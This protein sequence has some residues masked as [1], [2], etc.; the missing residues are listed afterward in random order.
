[1]VGGGNYGGKS[2]D[3]I[4]VSSD[5]WKLFYINDIDNSISAINRDLE[6]IKKERGL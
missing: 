3:T 5:V 4:S 6:I 2:C 1:M